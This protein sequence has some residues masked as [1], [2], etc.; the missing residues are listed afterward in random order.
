[1]S[2]RGKMW[3]LL[4]SAVV[5]AYVLIGGLPF[6]GNLLQTRAQQPI[7]DQGTQLRI[8]ESVLQ[9]I[10]N[11][12]VDPPDLNKVRLGALSGLVGSLD[13]YSSYLT[14]EQVKDFNARANSKRTGIGA[15]FSQVSQYLYVLSVLK[16]SNADKAGLKAGDVVEYIENRA[17]RDIS[18]YHAKELING[19]PGT[20]V[21]LRVLRSNSKPLV[22]KIPRG[23]YT[24]PKVETRVESGN[25]GVIKV[26]SLEKGEAADIK[27]QVEE[28]KK[29]K[30]EKIILDLRGVSAGTLD[31]AVEVSNLFVGSGDLATVPGRNKQIVRKFSADP[32]KQVFDGKVAV[33]IDFSTAGAAEVIAAS[34][35]EK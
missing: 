15:D 7:N 18:L 3:T 30:I 20:E 10:E 21:T 6:T 29:K 16:G 19:E 12:Y 27:T 4:I 8:F 11:D 5:A 22:L 17:T 28:L 23:S 26:F 33:L 35:L 13:P 32:A 24:V 14:V 2:F 25:V 1:M 31:Q 9:H 34:I